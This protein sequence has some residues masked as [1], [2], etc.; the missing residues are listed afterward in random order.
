LIIIHNKQSYIRIINNLPH[1]KKIK[2]R[3]NQIL[4]EKFSLIYGINIGI[5]ATELAIN[6]NAI[7][8]ALNRRSKISFRRDNVMK[9]I[10]IVLLIFL[11]T[12][13]VQ[14]KGWMTTLNYNVAIP[15]QQMK[16]L[17]NNPSLLGF[18]LDARKFVSPQFAIG[19]SLGNQVFYWKSGEHV[20]LENGFLGGNQYHILNTLPVM[21]TSQYYFKMPNGFRPYVGLHFGG[22]YAWQRS[23]MGIVVMEDRKWH[24]GMAPEAGVLVPIGGSL[25]NF[26][27]KFSY[28]GN[29]NL[30]DPQKQLFVSFYVGL[31]FVDVSWR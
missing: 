31:S 23:E 2:C 28:I 7:F 25:I 11:F 18:S 20:S 27:T 12:I 19:A 26:G 29:T 22:Y 24:W 15:G 16:P 14:S 8:I 9:A 30:G 4:L 6:N 1:Q 21:L 3:D 13:S 10:K 5:F 17:V